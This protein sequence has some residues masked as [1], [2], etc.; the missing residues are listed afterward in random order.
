MPTD[1]PQAASLAK[2]NRLLSP[3]VSPARD[4]VSIVCKHS[5]VPCVGYFFRVTTHVAVVCRA[6]FRDTLRIGVLFYAQKAPN[7]DPTYKV[8]EGSV[9]S[10]EYQLGSSFVTTAL[11]SVLELLGLLPGGVLYLS[12]EVCFA[13]LCKQPTINKLQNIPI[14]FHLPPPDA[15]WKLKLKQP[16][17]RIGNTR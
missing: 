6:G 7:T 8:L 9:L 17:H 10:W 12:W 3:G 14:P 11:S 16:S 15:V 1:K 13:V 5:F 4:G 2:G